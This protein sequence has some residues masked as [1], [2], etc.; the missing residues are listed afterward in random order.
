M[1]GSLAGK[2]LHSER[3]RVTTLSELRVLV[4]TLVAL[5]PRS[6]DYQ[7]SLLS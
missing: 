1:N 4:Q 3:S 7:L 5:N 2:E 6:F